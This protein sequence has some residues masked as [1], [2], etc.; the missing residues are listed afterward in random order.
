MGSMRHVSFSFA[1]FIHVQE[2]PRP[3]I[4]KAFSMLQLSFLT[5]KRSG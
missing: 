5:S 3:I 2:S 4:L 1:I